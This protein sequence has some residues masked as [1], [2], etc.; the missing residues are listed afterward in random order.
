MNNSRPTTA[1]AAVIL[2][3]LSSL[4]AAPGLAQDLYGLCQAWPRPQIDFAD[5]EPG[6]KVYIDA[7]AARREPPHIHYWGDVLVRRP[8][9]Q[10]RADV[11]RYTET[12]RIAHV[13]GKLRYDLADFALEAQQG[14][15]DLTTDSGEFT[16]NAYFVY[17]RHGRGQARRIELRSS[18]LTVLKRANYTTCDIGAQH[19]LLRANTVKLHHD[20][21]IGTAYNAYA[22]FYG[23]PFFYLPYFSFPITG[24]RKTGFLP[25]SVGSNDD[26]GNELILPFYINIHPQ[27]D[28]TVTLHHYTQRGPQWLG[29]L[30]WLT[31]LGKTVIDAE[32]LRD[33]VEDSTRTLHGLRHE[34]RF[35]NGWEADVTF[36]QV[37]DKDYLNDFASSLDVTS[38][39]HL[40]RRA[41]TAYQFGHGS[42]TAR[43]QD[44]QTVD[45]TIPDNRRPYRRLPELDFDYETALAGPLHLALESEWVRFQRSQRLDGSRLDVLPSLSLRLERLWGYV[46]PKLSW[47]HTQYELTPATATSVLEQDRPTRTLAYSSV[48]AGIFLERDTAIGPLKLLH[49]LEPRVFYLNVPYQDQSD[50]PTFDTGLS[51]L[52]MA[53]LFEENRF[54]GA[55]RVGDTEQVSVSITSRLLEA[56]S[57]LE[58]L[59]LG[60]GQIYYLQ[61]RLITLR[62]D[63]RDQRNNSDIVIEGDITLNRHLKFKSDLLWD[64]EYELL[65]KR[66]FRLEYRQDNRK[67]FNLSY[68]VQGNKVTNPDNVAK[69]IDVSVLWPITRQWSIIGR[70]FHSI[71]DDRTIEKMWGTEFNNCCWTFRVVKRAL[72]VEADN[73][74]P[75]DPD[76]LGE[77][78]WSVWAQ[79]ELKG[80][81]SLGRG[82][83]NLM[84]DSI[85]GYTPIR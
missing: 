75:L 71:P 3:L 50:I 35:D 79:L 16:D 59:S 54:T 17:D 69:E 7:D 57:G 23:V 51:T 65:T 9:A 68:R 42:F 73:P 84:Q 4:T 56:D 64:T 31:T 47:R 85:L 60:M 22:T 21:G 27:M 81:T 55:D 46:I 19:W 20:R 67:I 29:E 33:Q 18:D 38:A 34:S 10:L 6:A 30:R 1:C 26:G 41:Q 25:P 45:E 36:I 43:I 52:N 53:Q 63:L 77:Q 72:F 83:D 66:D 37:S 24:E 44:Y 2:L 49:T 40:E 32:H 14:W 76:S 15:L 13:R 12:S 58:R 62:Q 11:L 78:R 8:D 5:P 48:D 82:I 70:R 28:A 39:S 80:L 74:D 61:N